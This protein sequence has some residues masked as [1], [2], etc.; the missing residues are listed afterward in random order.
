MRES[1][2]RHSAA[3]ASLASALALSLLATGPLGGCQSAARGGSSATQRQGRS[4]IESLRARAEAERKSPSIVRVDASLFPS[5]ATAELTPLSASELVPGAP[6]RIPLHELLASSPPLATK[7]SSVEAPSED[8]R[9]TAQLRYAQGRQKLLEGNAADAIADF[10]AATRLDPSAAELWRELGQAQFAAGR[11]TSAASSFRRAVELGLRDPHVLFTLARESARGDKIDEA[12]SLLIEAAKQNAPNADPAL[13]VVVLAELAPLLTRTGHLAAA[14]EALT[15]TADLPDQLTSPTNLRSELSELYRKRAESWQQIGDWSNRLGDADAALAAYERAAL[16]PGSDA[17]AIASRRLF[18]L[19]GAGRPTEAGLL[20]LDQVQRPDQCAGDGAISLARQLNVATNLGSQLGE[21]IAQ[22]SHGS[23]AKWTP[24]QRLSLSRVEAALQVPEAAMRTRVQA[25]TLDADGTPVVHDLVGSLPREPGVRASLISEIADACPKAAPALAE[26]FLLDGIGLDA[27]LS[28][29][30]KGTGTSLVQAYVQAKRG[31]SIDGLSRID[32]VSSWEPKA[33]VPAMLA[34]CELAA[35][36][37][38]WDSVQASLASLEAETTPEGRLAY[39]TALRAAQRPARA[40]ESLSNS[41]RETSGLAATLLRADLALRLGQPEVAA[42]SFT[43]VLEID[44]YD[45]RAYEGLMTLHLPTGQ[46]PDAERL[47]GTLRSLREAIPQ[48]RVAKFLTVRNALARGSKDQVESMLMGM[49]RQSP[50]NPIAL[51]LLT[52][53]WEAPQR[54]PKAAFAKPEQFLREMLTVHPDSP[55]VLASLARVL[56]AA[57]RV[58]EGETLLES[59]L[60]TSPNP[61]LARLREH[62]VRDTLKDPARADQLAESRLAQSPPTIDNLVER[63]E[64]QAKRGDFAAA[65]RTLAQGLPS[66]ATLTSEQS[67]VLMSILTKAPL[68]AKTSRESATGIVQLFDRAD[69]GKL[70]P[71]LQIK[72]LTAAAIAYSREPGKLADEVLRLAKA[73]PDVGL[74]AHR[75]VLQILDSIGERAATVG[76]LREMVVR[77]S[78]NWRD[79][80]A[81][82]YAFA[83]MLAG[84]EKDAEA[85][86]ELATDRPSLVRWLAILNKRLRNAEGLAPGTNESYMRA[87]VA[88]AIASGMSSAGREAESEATL[89]LAI[90][91]D[92]THGMANNDLGYNL[93]DRGER[94]DE[95]EQMLDRALAKE[96]SNANV[97]DSVAWLRYKRGQVRDETG[98]DGAVVREGAISMLKRAIDLDEDGENAIMRDHLGDAL[99]RDGQKENAIQAWREA[100]AMIAPTL[101]VLAERKD[102]P[103]LTVKVIR[104]VAES[105]RSKLAAVQANAEPG[106]AP[107]APQ[108]QPPATPKANASEGSPR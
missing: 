82:N 18:A 100:S 26:A 79:D 67:A 90:R 88:Y 4:V 96:P 70:L 9:L 106:I 25:L 61:T 102:D 65:A 2:H 78:S 71:V 76:F 39:A 22:V 51:E 93:A 57:G 15:P 99:W 33:R 89:S 30:S 64:L 35:S 52:G 42:D 58:D 103:S 101:A 81:E 44:R 49:V 91:F 107:L 7:A 66:D 23:S 13:R 10:Q 55:H 69:S 84:S 24:S 8:A 6:A 47:N 56:A 46:K 62:L 80:L 75:P 29:E 73:Q 37:A 19:L 50:P 32:S 53:L 77:T 54:D 60:A 36:S 87:E 63:A 104:T 97:L 74:T 59:S 48:G 85:L 20:L 11:R 16:F 98:A 28:R 21:A 68:D 72:R 45:E 27:L 17:E 105:L 12:R 94:L 31:R 14:R 5:L 1:D 108:P 3:L 43:H 86:L 40:M 41:D 92:P 34:R 95:A 83:I 38:R